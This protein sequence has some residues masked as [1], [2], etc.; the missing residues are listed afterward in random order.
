MLQFLIH[1]RVVHEIYDTPLPIKKRCPLR[2]DQPP[3]FGF[4][5]IK[6][7]D[8]ATKILR[9]PTYHEAGE[10]WKIKHPTICH[11]WKTRDRIMGTETV[12]E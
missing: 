7:D 6:M 8:G 1:H 5:V 11:W 10:F 3:G 9:P 12:D 2:S 4:E